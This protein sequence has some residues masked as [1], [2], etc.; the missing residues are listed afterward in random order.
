MHGRVVYFL[1]RF[2]PCNL[3]EAGS[4]SVTT[5]IIH[6]LNIPLKIPYLP[7][8][9]NPYQYSKLYYFSLPYD[10]LSMIVPYPDSSHLLYLRSS[11]C[12]PYLRRISLPIVSPHLIKQS[13][14]YLSINPHC[15]QDLVGSRQQRNASQTN[16]R[17]PLE[18]SH[19]QRNGKLV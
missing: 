18:Q 13:R 19:H 14:K 17:I 7:I 8:N 10:S 9:R 4:S 15:D 2:F 6:I 16:H 3:L 5:S 12:S 11:N 1:Q